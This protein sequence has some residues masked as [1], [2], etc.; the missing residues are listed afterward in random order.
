VIGKWVTSD[1][2]VLEI[3]EMETDHIERCID[4]LDRRIEHYH[5]LIAFADTVNGEIAR[6]DADEAA[7]DAMIKSF[8]CASKK[9]E[10]LRELGIRRHTRHNGTRHDG[11]S[12]RTTAKRRSEP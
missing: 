1:K 3:S 12:A 5:R 10:L 11:N 6:V 4:V 8:A 7:A 9:G 2:R